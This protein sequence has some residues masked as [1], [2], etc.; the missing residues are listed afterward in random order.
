MLWWPLN[1]MVN[2]LLSSP[3]VQDFYGEH[4]KTQ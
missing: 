4:K 2:G 3:I 1:K